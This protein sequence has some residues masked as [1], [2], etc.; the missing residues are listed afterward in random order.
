[1]SEERAAIRRRRKRGRWFEERFPTGT[2][3]AGIFCSLD[4]LQGMTIVGVVGD[5]RQQG[6]ER[7]PMA[8]C[9]TTYEQHAFYWPDLSLVVRTA[10]DPNALTETLRHPAPARLPDVPM[11]FTTI[12]A[13]LRRTWRPP[14][15]APLP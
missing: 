13:V 14:G 12:E 15:F 5:V 3:S 9:Y 11:K 1:M 4:S 10:D 7:E 8:E 2:P 6:P